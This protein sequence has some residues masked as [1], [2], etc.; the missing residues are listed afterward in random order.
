MA[1]RSR[2]LFTTIHTEGALLPPDLLQR[3]VEGDGDLDG[4]TPTSYHLSGE[5]LNEATNRAW[6]RLQGAWAAFKAARERLPAGDLGTSIT[7]ERWLLPLFSAL[8]Y[9]RLQTARAAE[10]DGRSYP[11]S[12]RWRNVPLH[13]VSYQLD[14]DRRTPGVA[15]AATASPHSLVQVYLNRSDEVLWGFLSNGL[16]LRILRDNDSTVGGKSAIFFPNMTPHGTHRFPVPSPN[17][18]FDMGSLL[19]NQLGRYMATHGA[20]LDFDLCQLDWSC[21]W[22]PPVLPKK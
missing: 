20:E 12:H 15:G 13:L 3:I 2:D 1:A 10:I 7:R 18:N 11:I 19:I 22:I 5:R 8:D 9:G 17:K 16:R 6:N 14:L 21:A 4:L